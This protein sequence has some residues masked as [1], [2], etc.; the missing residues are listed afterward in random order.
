MLAAVL[1]AGL[2]AGLLLVGRALVPVRRALASLDDGI[3]SFKDKDFSLR[4]AAGKQDEIGALLSL[5]NDIGDSLREQRAAIRQREVMLQTVLQATPMALV[6]TASEDRIVYAN[7]AARDLFSPGERLQGH[8]FED[9]LKGCP[10][11]MREVFAA[12]ADALFTVDQG[13]EEETFHVAQREFHLDTRRHTLFMVRRLTHELRR[14][15]VEIWKKVIRLM[16]HELNNSLAPI[17]SLTHSARRIAGMPEHAHRLETIFAT[18]EERASHL[19]SFLEGYARFARLPRPGKERVEWGPFLEKL[20]ALCAVRLEGPAPAGTGWFDPMQIQQAL[21]NLIKN[22]GESGSPAEEV[23]LSIESAPERG[24]RLRIMDRG[25]GMDEEV[26]RRSLV[27]FFSTKPAGMGL[28]LPLCR[29]IVEA[30]GGWLRVENRE[31]GG[32]MVTFWLPP[33]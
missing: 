30:H 1:A 25:S 6:L 23:L 31:G 2:A 10:G 14:Q 33:A 3:K 11:A 15:E 21:I 28:G 20:R 8:R 7:R 13:G 22:A 32:V 18:I 12:R 9:V 4:L 26:L 27:P 19:T 16:S 17:T 29:E 5:Y 24:A